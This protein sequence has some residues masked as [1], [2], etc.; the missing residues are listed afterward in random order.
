MSELPI[1]PIERLLRNAG[2]P[3]VSPDGAEALRDLMEKF[4]NE[5]AVKAVKLSKHARRRTIRAED[6][7]MAKEG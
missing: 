3:R 5:I 4:A 7:A 2:A 6:I 1:A